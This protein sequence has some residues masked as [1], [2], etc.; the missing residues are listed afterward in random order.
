MYLYLEVLQLGVALEQVGVDGD[1]RLVVAQEQLLELRQSLEGVAWQVLSAVS[2]KSRVTRAQ[3]PTALSSKTHSTDAA[4]DD[5]S[6]AQKRFRFLF[7]SCHEAPALYYVIANKE[8]NRNVNIY[9]I[10][11]KRCKILALEQTRVSLIFHKFNV[12]I[13]LSI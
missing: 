2:C 4:F 5:T 8:Y 11:F 3:K 10:L 6:M 1:D 7:A 12:W 9:R 13:C